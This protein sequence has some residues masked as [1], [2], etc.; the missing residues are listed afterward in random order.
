MG[1]VLG[2]MGGTIRDFFWRWGLSGG[3]VKPIGRVTGADPSQGPGGVRREDGSARPGTRG[4]SEGSGAHHQSAR[5]RLA[6]D[7]VPR[8][9]HA[10]SESRCRSRKPASS[11]RTPRVRR[12]AGSRLAG[13]PRPARADPVARRRRGRSVGRGA[14]RARRGGR[15]PR[16]ARPA[17]RGPRPAG[18]APATTGGPAAPPPDPSQTSMEGSTRPGTNPGTGHSSSGEPRGVARVGLAGG[19][20]VGRPPVVEGSLDGVFAHVA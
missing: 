6:T 8:R 13:R 14:R 4:H 15:L 12:A 9:A 7:G 16:R 19:V 20:P 1:A 18:R 5:A 2:R 10:G 3:R 17:G 11:G